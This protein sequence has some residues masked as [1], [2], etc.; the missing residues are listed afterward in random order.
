[1]G[2]PRCFGLPCDRFLNPPRTGRV[3]GV[4]V[5]RG[6]REGACGARPH[7][8]EAGEGRSG[9]L[10][11]L[12]RVHPAR[13][14]RPPAERW[15]SCRVPSGRPVRGKAVAGRRSRGESGTVISA[16]GSPSPRLPSCC[17]TVPGGRRGISAHC[18]GRAD[19]VRH[20]LRPPG[21]PFCARRDRRSACACAP[22]PVG[23]HWCAAAGGARHARCGIRSHLTRRTAF[24]TSRRPLTRP[25]MS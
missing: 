16:A 9:S 8:R 11:R 15:R 12:R 21:P 20:L 6:R 24:P 18:G 7:R 13:P 3:R 14:S 22:G 2:S 1:M 19:G 5:W 25:P 17:R 23:D 4:L 10:R